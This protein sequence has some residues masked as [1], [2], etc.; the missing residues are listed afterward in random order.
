MAGRSVLL[1]A[2]LLVLLAPSVAREAAAE[3][4][5]FVRVEIETYHASPEPGPVEP[6]AAALDRQL[7]R[8]FRY[9]SLRRLQSRQMRLRLNEIG[10]L[11]LPTGR[12]V[13]V[14]PLSLHGER[15]LMAVEVEG[16]LQTDLKMQRHRMVVI[17]QPQ[18]YKDGKLV[19]TLVPDF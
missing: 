7:S 1:V 10:G 5:Q 3:D 18:P 13:R 17:G 2:G 8:D 9:Q 16:T 14:R 11:E 12:W 4:V 15:V 6:N 19:I